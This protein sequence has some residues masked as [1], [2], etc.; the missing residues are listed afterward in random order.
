MDRKKNQ[1]PLPVSALRQ[2]FS[3]AQ[4]RFCAFTSLA[5]SPIVVGSGAGFCSSL[6]ALFHAVSKL[7]P[8]LPAWIA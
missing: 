1:R 8:G 3:K 2:D 5:A 6:S 4:T 7:M